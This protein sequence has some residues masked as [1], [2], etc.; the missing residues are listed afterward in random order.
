MYL[1]PGD[2]TYTITYR[3]S[4]QLGFFDNHDELYWNVTGNG[5]AFAMDQV[6]ATVILP[7]GAALT[8]AEAYTGP[9][10]ARGRDYAQ[11]SPTENTI[12]FETLASHRR[13]E[14]DTPPPFPP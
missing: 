2:Y 12:Q 1:P 7:P 10:G 3:T 8:S 9:S 14:M 11:S 4:R 13:L 5:W 6:T